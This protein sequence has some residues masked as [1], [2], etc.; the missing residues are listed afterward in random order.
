MEIALT[1][2]YLL[3][4]IMPAETQSFTLDVTPNLA[5]FGTRQEGNVWRIEA[6]KSD[7]KSLFGEAHIQKRQLIVKTKEAEI[8]VEAAD[9]L[10][11]PEVVDWK[12]L[13][14]LGR[15][16]VTYEIRRTEGK[17]E[18]VI[19]SQGAEHPHTITAIL[20]P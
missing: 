8:P 16:P 18:F 7:S 3:L 6:G 5:F 13:N 1:L 9:N 14:K 12:S 2:I 20:K 4:Q 17:I 15:D 10:A 11:L 19:T